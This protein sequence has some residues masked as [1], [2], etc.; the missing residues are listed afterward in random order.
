MN[1]LNTMKIIEYH[2]GCNE[3]IKSTGAQGCFGPKGNFYTVFG[4]ELIHLAPHILISIL[5]G[6]ASIILL[7][8]ANK[9]INRNLN[10][11]LLILIPLIIAILVFFI[12][13][14]LFPVMVVY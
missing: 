9:K 6:V 10:L 12:L 3:F 2:E 7:H 11:F 5:I 13:A 4:T 14:F 1:E 8:Y